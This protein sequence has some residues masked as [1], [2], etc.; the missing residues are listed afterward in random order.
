VLVSAI[1]ALFLKVA[2]LLSWGKLNEKERFGNRENWKDNDDQEE[3]RG[4]RKRMGE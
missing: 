1:R 3:K 2:F 4:K